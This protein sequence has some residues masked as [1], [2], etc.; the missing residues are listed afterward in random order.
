MKNKPYLSSFLFLLTY[1]TEGGFPMTAIRRIGRMI[2]P[3]TA[4]TACHP[5]RRARRASVA[6]ERGGGTRSGGSAEPSLRWR[7]GLVG[8]AL[9]DQLQRS[10]QLLLP[11]S[12]DGGRP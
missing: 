2:D 4:G 3:T 10:V 12:L 8:S 7:D 6:A 5:S 1:A 9:A 11:S